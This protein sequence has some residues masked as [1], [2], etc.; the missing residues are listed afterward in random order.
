M[1]LNIRQTQYLRRTQ[2]G[3][4]TRSVCTGWSSFQPIQVCARA[5]SR[6]EDEEG[7]INYSVDLGSISVMATNEDE[8]E[9]IANELIE[10][11][12]WVD[13]DQIVEP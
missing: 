1:Y 3:I 7:L 2:T 6:N 11:G 12:G 13:I 5:Q 10:K 8:A 4:N 9:E